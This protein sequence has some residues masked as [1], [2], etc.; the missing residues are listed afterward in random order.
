VTF[1]I[2]FVCSANVCRSPSAVLLFSK[3]LLDTA[4]FRDVSVHSAGTDVVSGLERCAYSRR[5]IDSSRPE[6]EPLLN[7][8]SRFATARRVEVADLILCA[9]HDAVSKILRANPRARPRVFTMVEGADLARRSVA[10][11]PEADDRTS[12]DGS[13]GPQRDDWLARLQWLVAEMDATRG[14]IPLAEP[15]RLARILGR[16]AADPNEILDVHGQ[17]DRAHG[18]MLREVK[19]VTVS[20]AETVIATHE[21]DHLTTAG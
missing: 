6:L 20:L 8:R 10:L 2:L 21:R 16:T 3:A 12:D 13:Y 1:K 15:G 7:R 9:D 18:K 11:L 5:H 17:G 4:V 19:T 14:Q